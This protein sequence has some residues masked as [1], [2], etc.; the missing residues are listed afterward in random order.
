M[1]KLESET[2]GEQIEAF[3][4]KKSK[5]NVQ[6]LI[7]DNFYNMEIEQGVP[8]YVR[9]TNVLRDAANTKFTA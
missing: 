7:N 9:R 3:L 2:L 8:F 5:K 4:L 1:R 6:N